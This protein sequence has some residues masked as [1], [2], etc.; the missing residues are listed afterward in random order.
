MK[1]FFKKERKEE[2]EL[3]FGEFFE[4]K[5]LRAP[6]KYSRSAHKY[7]FDAI[8]FWGTN[9]RGIPNI[10]ANEIFGVD[11]QIREFMTI[12]EAG[13]K[14]HDVRRR[15]ILFVG[16]VGTAKSTFVYLIKK[17]LEKYSAT[18]EGELYAI[19]ECPIHESPLNLIPIESREDFYKTFGIK[20]EQSLCPVCNYLYGKKEDISDVKVKRIYF[21]EANRL[22]IATFVPA[23]W[24][25]QDVSVLV[26]S[27]N[28]REVQ[29]YGDPAHPL[30]WNW[31]GS[32]FV[33]NRGLHE[34]TE[35]HKAKPDLLFPLITVAQER[36]VKVDRFGLIDV[37]EVLISHTNYTEYNK[38][39]SKKENEALKDRTRE[40]NWLYNLVWDEEEKIYKKMLGNPD[41]HIAPWTLKFVAGISIL[42]RLEKERDKKYNLL[43]SLKLYNHEWGSTYSEAHYEEMKHQ[44]DGKFGISPRL[45]VDALSFASIG[46]SCVT[47]ISAVNQLVSLV[48]KANIDITE[49]EVE[50]LKDILLPEYN[51]F[52]K[53]VVFKAFI[54]AS[55]AKEAQ[56]YVD[57]YIENAYA[58]VNGDKIKD[59]FTGKY[60]DADEKFLRS[61]EELIG[62]SKEQAKDF[63]TRLLVKAANLAS[64]G[65]KITYD[66][67]PDL[68]RAIEKKIFDDRATFIRGSISSVVKTDEQIKYISDA[69]EELKKVGFCEHCAKEAIDYVAYLLDVS[70]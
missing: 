47:P 63:R 38:F 50:M 62:I 34:F 59:P 51:S 57:R 58:F 4:H 30:A 56:T 10:F 52:I 66:I 32:L 39:V 12:L 54:G 35:L 8:M 36:N 37:D 14:G 2:T 29:K 60:V 45:A 69:I 18:D 28:F 25:S 17:A 11:D 13:A 31:N 22:G 46:K 70:R 7:L 33:A 68:K 16:P 6:H 67:H 1:T 21:S 53:D 48:A 42:S 3:T 44:N 23:D 55:F 5:F 24:T 40:I 41:Y 15:I 65:Q 64:K 43:V 9:E 20:I 61:L 26:G 19:S 27:E 49:K